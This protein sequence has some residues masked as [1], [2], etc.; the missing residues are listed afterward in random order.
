VPLTTAP[1]T[2]SGLHATMDAEL[3]SQLI[4]SIR[5]L[6]REGAGE[7]RV[8]LRP[9]VLGE[10]TIAIAV[11]HGAVTASIAAESPAVRQWVETNEGLLRE[12]LAEQGLHLERLTVSH[13]EAPPEPGSRDRRRSR[14]EEPEAPTRRHRPDGDAPRFEIVL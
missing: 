11:H 13:D 8:R 9:E 14:D 5:L 2:A 6:G 7:A 3:P 10:V 4:D 12:K 1:A